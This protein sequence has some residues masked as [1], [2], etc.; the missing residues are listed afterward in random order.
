MSVLFQVVLGYKHLGEH[1]RLSNIY[2]KE[3][4]K[5]PSKLNNS[6]HLTQLTIKFTDKFFTKHAVFLAWHTH[7][8]KRSASFVIVKMETVASEMSNDQKS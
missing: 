7:Y 2:Y 4:K 3:K 8:N 6:S 1:L 5:T